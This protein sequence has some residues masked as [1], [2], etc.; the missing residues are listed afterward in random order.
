MRQTLVAEAFVHENFFP[1]VFGCKNRKIVLSYSV[2]VV[3]YCLSGTGLGNYRPA[4]L[5]G[6]VPIG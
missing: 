3:M 1:K 4:V 2:A 6:L 5:L